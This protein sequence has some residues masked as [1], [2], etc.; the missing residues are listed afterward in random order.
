MTGFPADKI[1]EIKQIIDPTTANDE[2][3]GEG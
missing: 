1:T 3:G 2:Q